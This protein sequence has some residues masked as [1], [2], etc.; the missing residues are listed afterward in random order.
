MTVTTNEN[1]AN[2]LNRKP[3][4]LINNEWVTS[5]GGL[6]DVINPAT[7]ETISQIVNSTTDDV[8]KAVAAARAAF[9][10]GEWS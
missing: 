4:I 6:I 8:E 10:G 1:A 9:D 7:E 3:T 2:F 5:S